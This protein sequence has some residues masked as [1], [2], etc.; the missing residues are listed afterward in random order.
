MIELT[1]WDIS[2]VTFKIGFYLMAS[3]CIGALGCHRLVPHVN[4]QDII[5]SQQLASYGVWGA[6][7]GLI[8]TVLQFLQ[9]VGSFNET[10]LA[11]VF[12]V[13]IAQMLLFSNVGEASAIRGLGLLLL[14]VCAFL[15]SVSHKNQH[16]YYLISTCA[17]IILGYSFSV[18][19]H[20]TALDS[21]ASFAI[22]SHVIA[23]MWW[24][25]SLIPLLTITKGLDVEATKRLM[26]KFGQ[27]A[28]VMITGLIFAGGWLVIELFGSIDQALFTDYGQ[29][30]MIKLTLV[31]LMLSLGAF[32]KMRLVPK[33]NDAGGLSRLQLAI[34]MELTLGLIILSLTG[35]LTTLLGPT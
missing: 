12:D 2:A 14:L 20:V 29:L 17:V 23:A 21:V 22:T 30:L 8:M 6:A 3:L 28:V 1:P 32:N 26:I 24:L 18:I 9:Q 27:L 35:V 34:K 5:T 33:L 10:G 31:I 4:H 19:G 15:L 13:E 11:G 25:G 16:Y 7:G